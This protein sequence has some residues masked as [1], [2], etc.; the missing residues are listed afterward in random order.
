MLSNLVAAVGP[1]TGLDLG[2]WYPPGSAKCE[3]FV[4]R[5][6]AFC[7]PTS[8]LTGYQSA[9]AEQ[10]ADSGGARA[11]G[12]VSSTSE[13]LSALWSEFL[14]A[15]DAA[16]GSRRHILHPEFGSSSPWNRLRGCWSIPDD[17]S[18]S[19]LWTFRAHG[20]G[21]Q[22]L[23]FNTLCGLPI[24]YSSFINDITQVGIETDS[25]WHGWCAGF[26]AFVREMLLT[27][28][29]VDRA[30]S[31]GG[32][33]SP[34]SL[35]I[36]A[37]ELTNPD[38]DCRFSTDPRSAADGCLAPPWFAWSLQWVSGASRNVWQ[39][40]PVVGWDLVGGGAGGTASP[41]NAVPTNSSWATGCRFQARSYGEDIY[42]HAADIAA[43]AT[44]VDRILWLARLARDFFIHGGGG[45]RYLLAARQLANYALRYV[46]EESVLMVHEM[47]HKYLGRYS[48][49][50]EQ[51]RE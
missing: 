20:A 13:T 33:G 8:F 9:A 15:L 17:G 34:I 7:I 31:T 45:P 35:H 27:G 49:E 48:G 43:R 47:G 25:G 16:G 4:Y 36:N 50:S 18:A 12:P 1:G 10:L 44:I 22:A 19:Y 40:V 51:H 46:L 26:G 24:S 37:T 32:Y 23:F 2:T 21:A 42:F 38:P 11:F 3:D 29:G 5:D 14:D 6:V 41:N 30:P 28:S 39:I